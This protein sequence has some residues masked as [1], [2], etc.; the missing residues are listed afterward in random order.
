VEFFVATTSTAGRLDEGGQNLMPDVSQPANSPDGKITCKTCGRENVP[1]WNGEGDCISC[2][3]DALLG[4]Y[5]DELSNLLHPLRKYSISIAFEGKLDEALAAIRDKYIL[6]QD[7][8]EA[9][10]EDESEAF[11]YRGTKWNDDFA[12]ERNKL[13]T[14]I[15]QKLK[16]Q[17]F[18][19]D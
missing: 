16:L 10:G 1:D 4:K 7:V 19:N 5:E 11:G 2:S 14:E 13:R 3:R 12:V 18:Q 9:I 8:M 6:K 15:R 17:D